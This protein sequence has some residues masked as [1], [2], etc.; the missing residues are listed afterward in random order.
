MADQ[1]AVFN[2]ALRFLG[3]A[4]VTAAEIT[5]DAVKRAKVLNDL[6]EDVRKATLAAYPWPDVVRYGRVAPDPSGELFTD[7]GFDDAT[8]W[9][10][11]D[12][13]ITIS[14]SQCTWSGA[15]AGDADVYQ[16][17]KYSFIP[18]RAYTLKATV[19]YPDTS[20]A[21]TL[22]GH[23]GGTDGTAFNSRDRSTEEYDFV[24]TIQIGSSPSD[25]T[26]RFRGNS[27]WQGTIDT[28]SCE[29]ETG[30]FKA[31]YGIPSNAIRVYR[32]G[33]KDERDGLW[34][35][36]LANTVVRTDDFT[37]I[38]PF[39]VFTDVT[40]GWSPQLTL[41]LASHLGAWAGPSLGK[42]ETKSQRLMGEYKSMISDSRVRSR[43]PGSAEELVD[44]DVMED[45][46]A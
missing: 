30:G 41:A 16:T 5:A 4:P 28:V 24:D 17:G 20:D 13:A 33:D 32:F 43:V 44:L 31:Q 26:I 29:L 42:S 12:A 2:L 38:Q 37:G 34:E 7:T 21:G 35:Y 8:A 3:D 10:T 19:T 1:T 45:V 27:S 11:S 15:Q 39:V 6:W 18:S 40:T 25:Q 36:G 9:T 22:T 23:L 46:R 14:G